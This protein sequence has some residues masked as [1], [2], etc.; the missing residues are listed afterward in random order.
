MLHR[1]LARNHHLEHSQHTSSQ[2]LF[3][4]ILSIN[5]LEGLESLYCVVEVAHFVV[6][7]GDE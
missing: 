2:R 7:V 4:V 3:V 1:L 5:L 6:V